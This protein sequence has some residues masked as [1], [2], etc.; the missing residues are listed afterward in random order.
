MIGA[1]GA[2]AFSIDFTETKAWAV[3]CAAFFVPIGVF[4]G[5][6]VG[7]LAM[8]ILGSIGYVIIPN[9]TV[10][11]SEMPIYSLSDSS[12]YSGRFVLGS[13]Y[14]KSELRVYYVS[15]TPD[16]KRIESCSR[17][18]AY[19][20]ETND[21]SPKVKITGNRY[22]WKWA[23]WIFPEI[24]MMFDCFDKVELIVPENTITMQ[25]NIDLK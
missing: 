11:I 19:I 6:L 9:E 4:V 14:V 2:V 1:F 23:R 13:G 20:V 21:E 3:L 10:T 25:Y 8:L 17:Y 5:A 15:I 12:E 18:N 7:L 24:N 16:G 22:K